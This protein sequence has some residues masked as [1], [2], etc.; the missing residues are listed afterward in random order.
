MSLTAMFFLVLTIVCCLFS[1]GFVGGIHWLPAQIVFGISLVLFILSA[2]SGF[3]PSEQIRIPKFG[4][5][6]RDAA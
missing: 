6:P 2:L 3:T 1:F 5:R 4:F